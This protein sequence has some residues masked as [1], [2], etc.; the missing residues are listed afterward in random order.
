MVAAG[1][2]LLLWLGR[3]AGGRLPALVE[4]VNAQGIWAPVIFIAAYAAATLA[5]VPGSLLTL[6][7]GAVFGIVRG[8]AFVF[9]GAVIGSALAF[10]VSRHVARPMIERR[11]V[12]D[13]RF[14]RIDRAIAREGMKIVLLLRLSPVLPYNLLNYALGLTRV[15]FR[16]YLIASFGMIPG[17]LLFVYSG[18][19]AGD[20]AALAG[21]AQV[22]RGTSYYALLIVG[23]IATAAVTIW[24]TRIARRAIQEGATA[25]GGGDVRG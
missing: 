23:L 2:L 8:T 5:F 15:T 22:E 10:L 14:E 20:V 7:A 16:D 21:G 25:T 13:Q 1:L 9:I 17:T 19:V 6:A 12:G 11:I 3:V 24:I 4:W 18:K